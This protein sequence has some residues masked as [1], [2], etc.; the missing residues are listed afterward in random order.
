MVVVCSSGVC[1]VGLFYFLFQ[2]QNENGA[3]EGRERVAMDAA[4]GDRIAAEA[5]RKYASLGKQGKPQPHEWTVMAAVVMRDRRSRNSSSSSSS[6]SSSSDA[7][8]LQ[9]ELQTIALTTGNK[10]LW[11]DAVAR[12]SE[13]KA[14]GACIHAS[15]AEVCIAQR[16]DGRRGGSNPTRACSSS[17]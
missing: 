12:Q 3:P 15:H 7:R 2:R 4:L 9:D 6:N 17:S 1:A 10:C 11:R 14:A 8:H 16:R 13:S 5:L